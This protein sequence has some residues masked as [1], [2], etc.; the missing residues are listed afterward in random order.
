VADLRWKEG[1]GYD[2]HVLRDGPSSKALDGS[3]SNLD[4]GGPAPDFEP[5]FRGA[6]TP[7][8]HGVTV[9]TNTGEVTATAHPSPVQPKLRN[10]LMIARQNLAGGPLETI[11]RVHVH[12][13]VQKLWLTP[14]T[15]SVPMGATERRF[16]VLALFDDGVVGDISD[17]PQLAY[18]SSDASISV[19]NTGDPDPGAPQPIVLGGGLGI[20]DPA[21]TSV[22]TVDLKLSTPPTDLS[23]AAMVRARP[24]WVE[25]ARKS[26]VKFVKGPVVPVG[27]DIDPDSPFNILS[28]LKNAPNILFLAEGFRSRREF[29]SMV[30][31]V[32]KE[33]RTSKSHFPFNLLKDSI[34]YWSVFVESRENVISVLG[35]QTL[36]VLNVFAFRAP[37]PRKPATA[38]WTVHNMAHAGG[39]PVPAEHSAPDAAA[40]VASRNALYDMPAAVPTI[41]AKELDAWNRLKSRSLLNERDTAF[42]LAH[43]DR[44]RASGQDQSRWRLM[45]DGRRTSEASLE[46][47]VSNLAFEL[48]PT[49]GTSIR[50][51]DTWGSLLEKDAGLVCILSRDVTMGG[52]WRPAGSAG[53]LRAYFAANAGATEITVVRAA[54][55]GNDI[56][57]GRP[58][59]SPGSFSLNILAARVARG[60]ALALGLGDEYGNDEDNPGNHIGTEH[61]LQAQDAPLVT[62]PPGA[63]AR[64]IDATKIRWLWPRIADIGEIEALFDSNGILESPLKCDPNGAPNPAG[65]HLLIK[66][67][68]PHSFFQNQVVRVRQ[69]LPGLPGLV[70]PLPSE[71]KLAAFALEVDAVLGVDTIVVRY[72]NPVSPQLG[73]RTPTGTQMDLADFNSFGR[74]FLIGPRMNGGDESPLVASPILTLI[75][76]SDSPLDALPGSQGATCVPGSPPFDSVT[77]DNLP[78]NLKSP[79]DLSRI[80]GIYDGGGRVDCGV[81]RPAGSCRMRDEFASTMRFCHVCSYILVD[82]VDPTKHPRLDRYYPE[83]F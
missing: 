69:T 2:I 23:D 71:D 74:H 57:P 72:Q 70:W 83:V 8:N 12:D 80:I 26:G 32:V 3:F 47:F 46:S 25:E 45:L 53:L 9:T 1:E 77:P 5:R 52:A 64:V 78:P 17:W 44:P 35:D 62:S 55:N 37:L 59:L 68:G 54:A 60:C 39:L 29:D 22:I 81:F 65:T 21:G 14:S 43:Y 48:D 13:S 19:A 61:N 6:G 27:D 34:N 40:W 10:F 24:S 20:N 56:Q 75:D 66:M 33:L 58:N 67:R 16:T 4:P 15:L 18:R 51:G 36:D 41:S 7:N 79:D 28:V 11:I 63:T 73:Y 50:I 76:A 30:A 49:S 38:Q 82:I 42:G 31:S